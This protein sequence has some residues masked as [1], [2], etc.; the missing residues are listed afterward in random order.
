MTDFAN[1]LAQVLADRS[2]TLFG[3]PGGGPNLDL[4]SAATEVGMR[5][6]LSH[7]ETSAAIMASVYGL[8]TGGPTGV[9][10]T[11]GPGAAS[12][13]NGAAQATLD[14]FPLVM[15]TDTVTADQAPRISHQRLD[16]RAL[17]APVTVCSA[18]ASNDMTD[19]A[20]L[21]DRASQWP[22]GAVHLDYDPDA[23]SLDAQPPSMQAPAA[24]VVAD[25]IGAA[26][27]L[28]GN[29]ARP[30]VIV[31]MEAATIDHTAKLIGDPP[32]IR[33]LL[34][35]LDCPVLTTYQAVGLVPTEG[36][37]NAGLY[38]NGTL[39]Q[40][41]LD[42]ADLI[43]MIGVDTVEPIPTPWKQT[44]PVITIS[45][46]PAIDGFVVADVALVGDVATVGHQLLSAAGHGGWSHSWSTGDGAAMRADVRERLRPASAVGSGSGAR[47]AP[48]AGSESFGPIELVD[49]VRQSVAPMAIQP[50]VTVDAGAHFLAIMPLWP[51]AQPFDLLIS[52]GLAT[53]GFSI[54]AAIGGSLA[55]PGRPIVAFVGDGGLSMTLAELETIVRLQLP[56]TVVVFNDSALSLIAVKQGENDSGPR[57]GGGGPA[58][59]R[60]EATD[61]ATIAKASGL[62]GHVAESSEDVRTI[63]TASPGQWTRPRLIDARIDP[64][65]YRHI[66]GAT[67]G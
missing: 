2:D 36:S 58:A 64:A 62:D 10:V 42:Q 35:R 54:P 55:R 41:S 30:I 59:I 9:V 60:Y 20:G 37:L 1:R 24:P 28:V 3:V 23:L 7:G 46:A 49:A 11:R 18:T 65:D 53:M 63:L 6:V 8:I 27:Q 39:E 25:Q 13:V 51:V 17:F 4:V 67:R 52:N 48:E 40:P 21:V 26:L 61:F 12:A 14:R 22:P 34:E 66:I 5:F 29:S 33:G 19:L 50:T 56:I 43:V 32:P 44:V 45:S 57:T 31:G 15:I 16:Q 38:T 47:A